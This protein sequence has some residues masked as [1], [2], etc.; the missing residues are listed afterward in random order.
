LI[1]E[2]SK[3]EIF[4]SNPSSAH[5]DKDKGSTQDGCYRNDEAAGVETKMIKAGVAMI[6]AIGG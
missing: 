2:S 3:L 4:Q 6:A 1:R 5:G